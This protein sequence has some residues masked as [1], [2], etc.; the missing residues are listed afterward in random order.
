MTE[1]SRDTLPFFMT[2]P[3]RCPYLP[4]RMERKVFTNL[5]GPSAF[6]LNDILTH[7]GFRRSQSISYRPAC[8]GCRACISVRVLVDEFQPSSNMRRVLRDNDDLVG[9]IKPNRA[10]SEQYALFRDYLGVRH[11]DGGMVNMSMLDYSMMIQDS[12]VKTSLIE[13]RRRGP[14]TAIHGQGQGGLQAVA[15]TD[16][17]VDG[18]SMVYS[19]YSPQMQERS[20]GTY[21]ILDHIE[22]A[23]QMGLPYLY[24]GYWVKDS[25]KMNYKARFLPQERLTNEGWARA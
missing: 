21:L 1:Q 18:L 3:T 24:L 9:N 7:S 23:R 8:D 22:R 14:D 6:A 15:L 5:T 25:Q 17:L 2:G 19:F 12:H 20:L 10:T 11:N 13:Y 16:I 4:G